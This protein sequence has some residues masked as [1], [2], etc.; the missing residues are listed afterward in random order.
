MI[1]YPLCE[2]EMV[3][4]GYSST[5]MRVLVVTEEPDHF[6]LERGTFSSFERVMFHESFTVSRYQQ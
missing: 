5:E 2:L 6:D 4:R 1:F 3:V